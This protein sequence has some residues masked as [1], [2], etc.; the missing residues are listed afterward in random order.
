MNE[1]APE[2]LVDPLAEKL[3]LLRPRQLRR[4]SNLV[5]ALIEG[6]DFWVNPDSDFAN[7]DFAQEFGDQLRLHHNGS[8][9]PLTKDKFEYALVDA[10]NDTGHS[11]QKL[12]NGNPGEDV[13][14]DGSPWSLKTQAD[15]NIKRDLI[16]ISKFME[17]GRGAWVTE[18]DIAALRARMFAHMRAYDRIFTLRCLSTADVADVKIYDYELVEIPKALLQSSDGLPIEI[19]TDSRQTPKPASCYVY[20]SRGL[21]FELY[22][23]GGT[24]RKLQVRSLAKRNCTVHATWEVKI[25]G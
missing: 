6:T 25:A 21:A 16:H 9:I 3:T 24:E 18:E 1:R 15:R 23:D 5:D 13:V 19:K 11:A 8:L 20:D 2:N 22:F 10:L 4:V 7:D 12:P 17:L 14:V